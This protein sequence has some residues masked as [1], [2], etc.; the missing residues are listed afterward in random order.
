MK[1]EFEQ[2]NSFN[3]KIRLKSFNLN[4]IFEKLGAKL[5]KQKYI[6]TLKLRKLMSV[7]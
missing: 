4:I 5:T 2:I 6:I 1:V 7:N 3:D